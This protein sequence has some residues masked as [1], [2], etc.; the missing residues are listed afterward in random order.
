M[1]RVGVVTNPLAPSTWEDHEGANIH[2]LLARRFPSWPSS[3]RIYDLEGFGDWKR[4]AAIVDPFILSR[5]DVTPHGEPGTK[6]GD[7]S[8]ARLGKLRGPVLVI[9][10]PA[11]PITAIFAVVAIAVG[12]A[13]AF[14]FMP[15]IPTNTQRPVS[16]NNQLS[17]RTNQPRVNG[18]VADIYGTVEATPD[19]LSVPYTVYQS[20]RQ[21]EVSYMSLGRGSYDVSRVRDGDTSIASIAGSSAAI[22]APFTSPNSGDPPQLQIGAAIG[23]PVLSVIKLNEVNGQ[24]LKPTNLNRVQGEDDIRFVFPDSIE[25]N[26]STDFTEYFAGGDAIAV[27]QANISG[28]EPGTKEVSA[29]MRFETGGTI[30]FE[31]YNPTTD[32]AAADTVTLS[33]ASYTGQTA[34][35][36][37]YILEWNPASFPAT[38]P[39]VLDRVKMVRLLGANPAKFY[40][41]Y[42]LFYHDVGTRAALWIYQSDD[43][44]GAGSVAVAAFSADP[45]SVVGVQPVQLAAQG[46]SGITGEAL[47]DFGDGT[48]AFATYNGTYADNGLGAPAITTGSGGTQ[49]VD[50]IGTYELVSVGA[51]TVVLDSAATVNPDWS[52]L[53]NYVN[54]RTEYETSVISKAVAAG[55]GINLNGNYTAASVSNDTIVLNNP[56]LVNAAWN[57]LDDLPGDATAYVSPSLSRNSESWIGPYIVDLDDATEVLA[58]FVALQ[59]LYTLSK[60]K[61]QQAAL[62]VGVEL[63]VTPV[64]SNDAAI[65]PAELFPGTLVGDVKERSTVGLSLRVSPSSTGRCSVRARRTTATPVDEDYGAVV[66][67]VKWETCY[68]LAPVDLEDFGDMTTVHT[69]TVA[70]P[71]AL[72]VK[73]RKLNMRV[74]RRLPVRVSGSTFG[75]PAATD[76]VADIIAAMSLDPYIGRRS[77]AEVDF[78]SIYDTV[79]DV[80][81][82]FGTPLAGQFGYTFDDPD[83][84]FEETLGV[85]ASTIF[86][87]AYRQGSVLR[88][89]FERATED[90]TLIFNARNTL[91]GTQSRTV[92]FGP[93]DDHDGVELEYT[94]SEDGA[95]L[96]FAIPPDGSATSPRSLEVVGVRSYVLAYWQAWRS[97]NKVR[98]QNTAVELE[99]TQEAALVIPQDRVLIADRTR[100]DV[101]QGDVEEEDGTTLKLSHMAPITGDGW[102]IFLQHVDGTVEALGVEAGTDAFHVELSA[103]PRMALSVDADNFARATYMLVPE[104]DVQTRAF[105]VSER[106]PNGNFTETLRAINYSFLYYQHDELVLWFPFSDGNFYD[107]GPYLHDGS[108]SGTLSTTADSGRNKVV[109]SCGGGTLAV[110]GFTIPGSYTKAAWLKASSLGGDRAIL[111]AVN[112]SDSFRLAGNN[113][114]VQHGATNLETPWPTDGEWHHAAV[115]YDVDSGDATLFVDGLAET[116]GTLPAR[117]PAGQQAFASFLG[118]ADDLRVWKRAL[119]PTEMRAVFLSTR[120]G[121]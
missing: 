96:T 117:T 21:V 26:G 60:K 108:P 86:C 16:P 18:R 59:G 27:L 78:D 95:A 68:G 82:Y 115:A 35:S 58:N 53:P 5:R 19:L 34:A 113:L 22:Y 112:A 1:I 30:R 23:E 51:T 14:L 121:A 8:I 76:S 2:E 52:K 107:D 48:T 57:D 62:S 119:S 106:E 92:R 32:F 101:L 42:H 120:K 50:L 40:R 80:V 102:T 90:S 36:P 116:E 97:W 66:D 31:S 99:A 41:V 83:T 71:G 70:T 4:A 46:G 91:P 89:A 24:T 12:I 45:Y 29:R 109:A 25:T 85:V 7:A 100:P 11:D 111:D 3:A 87:R 118:R 67:E 44:A 104:S 6:E 105:L 65:G 81:A 37:G 39:A 47:V 28:S 88:L 38:H 79:A 56:A 9:V 73:E 63:E 61:G 75:A 110:P 93:L 10:P 17:S 74:T 13:A 69:R 49:F 114:R 15:R 94:D 20:N 84:S 98:Y 72:A 77:P 55:G 64:N 43:A 33:Q 103:A 54:A